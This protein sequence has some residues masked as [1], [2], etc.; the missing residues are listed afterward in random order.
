[1][2]EISNADRFSFGVLLTAMGIIFLATADTPISILG[3]IPAFLGGNAI[4]TAVAHW[5]YTR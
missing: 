4:G 3:V 2:E 5:R 1:M